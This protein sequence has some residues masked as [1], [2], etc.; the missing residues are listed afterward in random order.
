MRDWVVVEGLL[1][2]LPLT[3]FILDAMSVLNLGTSLFQCVIDMP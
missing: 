1:I 3:E 2:R